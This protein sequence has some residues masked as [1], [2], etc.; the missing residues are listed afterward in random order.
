MKNINKFYE[1]SKK[2]NKPSNLLRTFF[3]MNLDK[4]LNEKVAIDLGAGVGNDAK[5]LIDNGFKVICI[6]KEEKSKEAIINKIGNN[7][8]LNFKLQD[9][10]N[11]RLNKANL[12]YSCFSLHFC[13]PDKFDGL[14]NEI[15]KSI[16]SNGF[17]VRKFSWYRR[18]ME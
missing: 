8:N 11:I 4:N 10:E 9:F 14:M 17:F 16:I 1:K 18:W 3:N 6:D 15:T 5:F 13:K 2:F 7:T 12:I